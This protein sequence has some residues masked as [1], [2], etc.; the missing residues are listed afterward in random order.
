MSYYLAPGNYRNIEQSILNPINKNYL[1]INDKS[2]YIYAWAISTKNKCKKYSNDIKKGDVIAIYA[3]DNKSDN[4][5]YYGVVKNK[6]IGKHFPEQIWGDSSKSDYECTILIEKIE[7]VKISKQE[8]LNVLDYDRL[9]GITL[10]R[11]EKEERLKYILRYYSAIHN[12][13]NDDE[14]LIKK[15]WECSSD[16]IEIEWDTSNINRKEQNL[17]KGSKPINN[18]INSYSSSKI[19][20]L[21][22]EKA[23]YIFLKREFKNILKILKINKDKNIE[24]IWFNHDL[25]IRNDNEEDKSVGKGYDIEVDMEKVKYKFE[26]KSSKNKV[27]E[28]VLTR[29]ELIEMKKSSDKYFIILVNDLL[30]KPKVRI[31]KNFS[32]EFSEEY[33]KMTSEHKLYINNVNYKYYLIL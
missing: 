2:K 11:D 24:I 25:E 32:E 7:K 1:D 21:T 14:K 23:A 6:I 16:E 10:L 15:Y 18:K 31:I 4:N 20:G 26:V 27:N 29:N 19:D 13:K 30:T 22:G 3:T 12:K 9:C 5:L 33:L 8:I 17:E 28:V